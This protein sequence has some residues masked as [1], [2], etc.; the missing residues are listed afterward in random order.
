VLPGHIIPYFPSSGNFVS[1]SL[2]AKAGIDSLGK[3]IVANPLNPIQV[4]VDGT[5][6]P[7]VAGDQRLIGHLGQG[8]VGCVVSGT[9]EVSGQGEHLLPANRGQMVLL[10]V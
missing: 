9:V 6:E 10:G 3:S 8:Q 7:A 1:V 4:L 5:V 2:L